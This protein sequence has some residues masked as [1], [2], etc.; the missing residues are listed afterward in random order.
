VSDTGDNQDARTPGDAPGGSPE[1]GSAR[2]PGEPAADSPS[3]GPAASEAREPEAQDPERRQDAAEAPS[4]A[5]APWGTPSGGSAAGSSIPVAGAAPE[6]P[7]EA[8][9]RRPERTT[10]GDWLGAGLTVVVAYASMLVA[11]ALIAVILLVMVRDDSGEASG[12]LAGQGLSMIT[13]QFGVYPFIA[14]LFQLVA[15]AMGGTLSLQLLQNAMG[16]SATITA[17]LHAFPLLITLVGFVVLFYAS[18]THARRQLRRGG[19]PVGG[20]RLWLTSLIA[21][22]ILAALTVAL[23]LVLAGRGSITVYIL[24]LEYWFDAMS[25]QLVLLPLIGGTLVSGWA[26]CTVAAPGRGLVGE[27]VRALTPGLG[28]AARLTG[29]YAGGVALVSLIVLSVVA[30]VQGSPAAGLGTLFFGLVAVVEIM[31]LGHLSGITAQTTAQ[32]GYQ[33]DTAFIWSAPVQQYADFWLMLVWIPIGVGLLWLALA[34]SRRRPRPAAPTSW[35]A[36][37]LAFLLLGLLLMWLGTLRFSDSGFVMQGFYGVS[38]AWLTP[39]CM[40]GWGVV[41]EL[42]ARFVAPR[43]T[44]RRRRVKA[45]GEQAREAADVEA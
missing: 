25:P 41:V 27:T 2:G 35:F 28:T 40:L 30:F 1:P 29:I 8:P 10:L 33:R 36:M 23:T 21:G 24:S 4:R 7:P 15:M 32:L 17:S 34:W 37:P 22:L 19:A 16:Q 11:A 44:R 31:A 45:E 5:E 13:D 39:A 20:T 12:T 43:L 38:P 14:L 26:R 42:L 18:R 9:A 6:E 3:E